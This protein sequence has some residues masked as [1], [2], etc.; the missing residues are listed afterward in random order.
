MIWY[1][2]TVPSR[3]VMTAKSVHTPLPTTGSGLPKA[4]SYIVTC[5]TLFRDQIQTLA[6]QRQVSAADLVRAVL[7]LVSPHDLSEVSDPG[8]AD[9]DDRETVIVQS[10]AAK[11]RILKRKPRLQLRLP[12]TLT[13]ADIRKA[14]SLALQMDREGWLFRTPQSLTR[15]PTPETISDAERP[16]KT[17]IDIDIP[18]SDA[19]LDNTTP[20]KTELEVAVEALQESQDE[21]KRLHQMIAKLR[22]TPLDDGVRTR[23]EALFILGLPPHKFPD[24]KTIKDRFRLMAKIVHPDSLLGDH[25]RMAQLNDA[26]RLLKQ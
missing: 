9:E 10:G 11:N 19:H 25:H 23:A 20:I 21:I 7:L 13:D 3:F 5:A 18:P 12:A 24:S 4:K 6:D 22:F 1:T 17:P 8:D 14:L 16:A 2:L 15:D 26:L